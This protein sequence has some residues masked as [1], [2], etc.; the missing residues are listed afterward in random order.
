M[1]TGLL[2]ICICN[3]YQVLR[4]AT[5]CG[6]NCLLPSKRLQRVDFQCSGCDALDQEILELGIAAQARVRDAAKET[7]AKGAWMQRR[8]RMWF[9]EAEREALRRMSV[10]EQTEKE[11]AIEEELE[12]DVQRA[13]E[14]WRARMEPLMVHLEDGDDELQ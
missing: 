2:A 9:S 5:R 3:H 8:S 4:W 13:V 11:K 7:N 6:E 14:E 12:R 10:A 1:C